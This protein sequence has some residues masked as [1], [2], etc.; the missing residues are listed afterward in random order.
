M[1]AV[2]VGLRMRLREGAAWPAEDIGMIDRVDAVHAAFDDVATAAAAIVILR[3]C[4]GGR[5]RAKDAEGDRHD[6]GR[7]SILEPCRI[8]K[9]V[10]AFCVINRA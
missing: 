7:L 4:Q 10:V 2:G 1:H 9:F 5:G 8:S 3:S 6:Q